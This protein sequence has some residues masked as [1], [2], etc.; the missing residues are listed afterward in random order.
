M[1]L[2]GHWEAKGAIVATEHLLLRYLAFSTEIELPFSFA[3][4]MARALRVSAATARVA[5]AVLNDTPHVWETL[6]AHHAASAAL[7]VALRC[8]EEE[9]RMRE[10]TGVNP[11]DGASNG[12]VS[13]PTFTKTEPSVSSVALQPDNDAAPKPWWEVCGTPSEVL[14]S[15]AASLLGATE[16]L[17][18]DTEASTRSVD[19]VHP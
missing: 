16:H 7:F 17:T 15:A 5:V 1:P 6:E 18:K 12:P 19:D 11:V 13:T 4:N 3:L 8:T 2:S 10:L 9:P 14:W